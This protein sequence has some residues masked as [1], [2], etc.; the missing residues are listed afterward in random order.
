MFFLF[1]MG[2]DVKESRRPGAFFDCPRC[3]SSQPCDIVRLRRTLKLYSVI[4]VWT[5]TLGE[6][7]ACQVCGAREGEAPAAAPPATW[8]CPRCGNVNPEGAGACLSCGR[9][10]FGAPGS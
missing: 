3:R 9:G 7:R 10:A 4:P 6:V 8:R 2:S 5:R 1:W